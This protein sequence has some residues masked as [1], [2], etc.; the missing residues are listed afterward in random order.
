MSVVWRW[1]EQD[2][3]LRFRDKSK[4]E[5]YQT[6]DATRYYLIPAANRKIDDAKALALTRDQKVPPQVQVVENPWVNYHEEGWDWITTQDGEICLNYA[7][8]LDGDEINRREDEGVLRALELVKRLVLRDEPAALSIELIRELHKELMGVIYPFAGKWRLVD[9]HK[10]GGPTRWPLPPAGIEHE[11]K[12]FERDV[13]TRSP[14]LSEDDAEVF[15]WTSE[16]MNDFLA[17]H[18]FREGNGRTAFVIANLILMQND[19]LPLTTYERHR[20]RERYFAA[21]DEGRIHRNNAPLAA[22]LAEWEAEAFRLWEETHR[23]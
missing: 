12:R 19:L 18:P 9:L 3:G 21:C 4:A 16:V 20:D 10:G 5:Y 7:G 2:Y 11:M 23:G 8:C 15:A 1:E 14:F 22:L 17:I 6:N 13:L